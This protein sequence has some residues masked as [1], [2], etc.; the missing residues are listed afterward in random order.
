MKINFKDTDVLSTNMV[1]NDMLYITSVLSYI[2]KAVNNTYGPYSGYVSSIGSDVMGN[3]SITYTKDGYRT[4]SNMTF[5]T[6]IDS[7]ILSVVLNLARAVKEESGDGSTTAVKVLYNMVRK[8]AEKILEDSKGIHKSRINSPKAIELIIKHLDKAIDKVVNKISSTNDIL[9]TAYIALNNDEELLN[10]FIEIINDINDNNIDVSTGIE[11]QAFKGLGDK[12]IVDKNPGFALGTYTFVGRPIDYTLENAKVVLFSN[13]LSMDYNSFILRSLI[14]DAQLVGEQTGLHTLY[15]C[16][17]LDYSAK[18]ELAKMMKR[19]EEI[20]ASKSS[21]EKKEVI[22]CDFIEVSYIYDAT[23]YKKEDLSYF[24]NVDEINLNDFCEKRSKIVVPEIDNMDN[25]ELVKWRVS[26]DENGKLV[27]DLYGY[28]KYQDEL[29]VQFEKSITCNVSYIHGLGLSITPSKDYPVRNA[30]YEAHIE[31]LKNV[32]KESKEPDMV[33]I[34]KERLLYM[35]ENYYTIY[36]PLRINDSDRIFDAYNDAARAVTAMSR[37]GYIMGG[38]IGAIK[39]IY[40]IQKMMKRLENSPVVDT[41]L[42]ILAILKESYSEIIPL[43]YEEDITLEEAFQT[44][45]IDSDEMYFGSTKVIVPVDT[46]KTIIK[47]V[48]LQFSNFF[49]SLLFEFDSPEDAFIVK[50]NT[51]K[52]KN[53]I[54][55]IAE[56]EVKPAKPVLE[57][58]EPTYISRPEYKIPEDTPTVEE[59]VSEPVKESTTESIEDEIKRKTKEEFERQRQAIER[60]LAVEKELVSI[61]PEAKEAFESETGVKASEAIDN[62]RKSMDEF[63]NAR[64]IRQLGDGRNGVSIEVETPAGIVASDLEKIMK[65]DLDEL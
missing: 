6:R 57:N 44:G 62:I 15:I 42:L 20:N 12:V 58:V 53:N 54:K 36:S 39:I 18:R 19:D 41:A 43:L 59:P 33:R 14:E 46:D 11:I 48:L 30:S 3:R 21:D 60:D 45:L 9:D 23:N 5:N 65:G 1:D 31:K 13:N 38:S 27:D 63:Y 26:V 56:E 7:D 4:L 24:L 49:S 61:D 37:N 47:T 64:N 2:D 55:G 22:W 16:S 40:E 32:V 50:S 29:V 8:G 10:P 51:I 28:R 34:A 17:G 52:I 35:K 25:T